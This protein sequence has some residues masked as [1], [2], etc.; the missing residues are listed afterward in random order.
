VLACRT[1]SF[2]PR[3]FGTLLLAPQNCG[4]LSLPLRNPTLTLNLFCSRLKTL[5]IFSVWPMGMHSWLFRLQCKSGALQ[6]LSY[7]YQYIYTWRLCTVGITKPFLCSNTFIWRS[8]VHKLC[9]SKTWRTK[10]QKNMQ[11]FAHLPAECKIPA[12]P[13]P[14]FG[15]VRSRKM[16]YFVFLWQSL[17]ARL[18]SPL[19]RWSINNFHTVG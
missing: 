12:T 15:G 14:E 13:R 19:T 6:M 10:R 2:G 3:S 17:C 1:S 5:R 16:E 11:L 4:T 18:R 8:G 9:R 7:I